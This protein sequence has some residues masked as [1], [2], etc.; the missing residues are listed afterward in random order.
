MNNHSYNTFPSVQRFEQNNINRIYAT[1]QNQND[2]KL[3][4]NAVRDKLHA[5]KIKVY[6]KVGDAL[7]GP[8]SIKAFFEMERDVSL[9]TVISREADIS[10]ALKLDKG[11]SVIVSHER[12]LLS[13]EFPR[14]EQD[15]LYFEID[16]ILQN[17]DYTQFQYL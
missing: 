13:I 3:Q 4:L 8:S 2:I 17:F 5:F 15:R 7:F 9:N 14:P 1:S 16:E 11:L 12:G 6:P 10:F